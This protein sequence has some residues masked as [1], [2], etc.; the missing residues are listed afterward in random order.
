MIIRLKRYSLFLRVIS[1]LLPLLAFLLSGFVL[2]S[3]HPGRDLFSP[4]YLAFLLLVSALWVLFGERYRFAN[5]EDLF[6][7]RTSIVTA[8]FATASTYGVSGLVL[9]LL[10]EEDLRRSFV[11]LSAVLLVAICVIQ[12]A[13]A[14]MVIVR[15]SGTVDPNRVLIVGTDYLARRAARRLRRMPIGRCSV[16]GYVHLPGTNV[17]TEGGPVWE[18]DQLKQISSDDVDEIVLA[19]PL[20]HASQLRPLMNQLDRISCP[21]RAVVDLGNHLKVREK[22]YQFGRLQLLDLSAAPTD[23]WEYNVA[24]RAFDFAFSAVVLGVTAPVLLLIAAAVKFSSP[25]PVFFMQD[26][27][28][29]NGRVFRMYKFRTMRV[30]PA[31][32]SDTRWTTMN[33]PR[34]TALGCF[35]RKTNLD[36][37]PQFLNVLRGDMSVVGPRP[38]RPHF[39]EQ[40]ADNVEKYNDRHRMQVGITGWAQVNGWRGDTSIEKRVECD[41]YYLQNWSF[42]LDLRIILMTLKPG[43]GGRNAY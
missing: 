22:L 21:I 8:S 43:M 36:E 23:T 27:V 3:V 25:G 32:E 18:L 4:R 13:L 24:K 33:D 34:R 20:Q 40:F 16:V 29:W 39:V 28:G 5:I 38:E 14:R 41:L 1:Y 17:R 9:Y 37:L 19:V 26:R 31:S 12:R 15:L 6:R 2:L 42:A 30:A 10:R 35:L 11:V 7:Q